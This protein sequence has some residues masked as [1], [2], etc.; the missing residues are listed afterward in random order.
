[1]PLPLIPII[2]GGFSFF[3]NS[4]LGR[5]LAIAGGALLAVL[6]VFSAGKRSQRKKQQIKNLEEHVDARLRADKAA[7][8]A[9]QVG[10]DLSDDELNRR[11]DAAGRLRKH[12]GS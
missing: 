11:L 4:W 2:M 7:D 9:R 1:M 6:F 8:A 12:D 5:V 3:K 10:A